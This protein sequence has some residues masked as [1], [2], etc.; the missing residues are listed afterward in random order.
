MF[1]TLHKPIICFDLE[2][3]L[4]PQD[5][6]YEVMAEFSKGREIFEKISRYD[7][8]LTLDGRV[9][10]EP[11]DTLSLIVPFLLAYNIKTSDI[12]RVSERAGI[13]SGAKELIER[14]GRDGW[15]IYI[16]ST[17]YGGHAYNIGRKLGIP[18]ENIYCT[19][20]NLE[21]KKKKTGDSVIKLVLDTEKRLLKTEED[22]E[23]KELLDE[24]FFEELSKSSYDVLSEVKVIGGER[25]LD[26]VL[27]ISDRSKVPLDEILVVGD[28]I[29]DYKMLEGV[30]KEEGVSV[31]FNGN[32]YAI[33]YASIG[34][35]TT[36]MRWLHVITSNISDIFEMVDLW[37][38]KRDSDLEF[39][40][41]NL[42]TDLTRDIGE[43]PY[44]HNLMRRNN[45][46][47]VIGIHKRYREMMRGLSAKLG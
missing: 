43:L 42:S 37:E 40:K 41:N 30:K 8:L 11:G 31:V 27:E 1:P 25:K 5:N 20:L 24:L 14:V 38:E 2:G 15:E 16:I 13:I 46:D 3:P 19:E 17:S 10:Y 36:D 29:T 23:L 26:A 9:G 44:I 47:E 7:D 12:S 39:I 6:A 21:E 18:R 32:E 34:L 35:A 22:E 45:F 33:P 4:S 28:S